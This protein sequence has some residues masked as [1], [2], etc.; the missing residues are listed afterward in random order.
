VVGITSPC[1]IAEVSCNHRG[2]LELAR[3]IVQQAAAAGADA[4]KFQAYDPEDMTVP[5]IQDAYYLTEGPWAGYALWDLYREARTP[6]HWLPE[7]FELARSLDLVPFASAFSPRMVDVVSELRPEMW[8]I[9]SAEVGWPALTRAMAR[10]GVPVL[11]STGAATEAEIEWSTLAL[12]EL[13]V[14]MLCIAEYP[15]P[16]DSY[17]LAGFGGRMKSWG[18]SDH[19]GSLGLWTAAAALGAEY[20]EGH[21]ALDAGTYEMA[22]VDVPLDFDHSFTPAAFA[23]QAQTAK[24]AAQA[25][26]RPMRTQRGQSEGFKRRLVWARSLPAGHVI[27]WKHDVL[28]VRCSV[29]AS[30]LGMEMFVPVELPEPV[31]KWEP[32]HPWALSKGRV[33][34]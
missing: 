11:Y 13:G 16:D 10:D 28:A 34:P 31:T 32:V 21:L 2:S 6:T 22:G 27:D 20:I 30:P 33:E 5:S 4:V 19:S 7:L 15:A 24:D 14:P 26:S 3:A 25:A 17:G 18:L 1:V 23:L 12:G 8:K 29:G 9:A